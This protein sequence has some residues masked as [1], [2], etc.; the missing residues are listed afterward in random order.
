[1]STDERTGI[2]ML[3][4]LESG[5]V[6][7]FLILVL[8]VFL[9]IGWAFP[10]KKLEFCDVTSHVFSKD[11]NN[12][13]AV[14]CADINQDGLIDIYFNNHHVEP[15][16]F[17]IN[18]GSGTFSDAWENVG[19]R[20]TPWVSE[21][22]TRPLFT[23]EQFGYFIW[24]DEVYQWRWKI[25]WCSGGEKHHF[26]GKICPALPY[27]RE[28]VLMKEPVLIGEGVEAELDQHGCITFSGSPGAG[29]QGLDIFLKRPPNGLQFDLRIDGRYQHKSIFV[30]G[31]KDSPTETPFSLW[32]SDRHACSW[33]DYNNDGYPDLFINRGALQGDLKPPLAGKLD[34]LYR[35]KRDGTLENV[36][37]QSGFT[38]NYLS[39]R[40]AMWVDINGDSFLDLTIGS[41][42]NQLVFYCNQDGKY[43]KHVD[44]HGVEK[45]DCNFF[46]WL[47]IDSDGDQDLLLAGCYEGQDALFLNTGQWNFENIS[48]KAGFSDTL[49]IYQDY[50]ELK[51]KGIPF[52]GAM[53]F[54]ADYDN[55]G[56]FDLLFGSPDNETGCRLLRNK[57]DISFE[58]I[59]L[60]AGL[61][62]QG[63]WK[64][65]QWADY[66]NDG[67]L[68]LFLPA[69]KKN[70]TSKLFNNNSGKFF[71]VT[72]E[73]KLKIKQCAAASF[74]DYNNDGFLDL[75]AQSQPGGKG[76]ENACADERNQPFKK[77][78]RHNR[79]FRNLGNQNHWLFIELRGIKSNR[80]G[81]GAR[82]HLS[83]GGKTQMRQKGNLHKG[84]F[85]QNLL[86]M[87]FGLGS[88][89][90]V[91]KIVIYWPSGIRQVLEN[92]PADQCLKITE[93]L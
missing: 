1:M 55:D 53:I 39:G 38:P 8:G 86:P 66:D 93:P 83:A 60:E 51:Q 15:S 68:D 88:S 41:A 67:D 84:R 49:T 3:A 87:H 92:I 77:V 61:P 13:F 81:L 82:I 58:N 34:E 47:D 63:P 65:G 42:N 69:G 40:S 72:K 2:Y 46:N 7:T 64:E 85:S 22:F 43:F 28:T 11:T 78:G 57:G 48:T 37:L 23:P 32:L 6:R 31:D 24:H 91:D 21:I 70:S 29:L 74:L 35:S 17:W 25:R 5:K 36:F 56:D 26:S 12:I 75:V 45:N 16:Q 14:S 90:K 18:D 4:Y 9:H 33:G 71:D 50:N 27:A 79:L 30:G 54:P 59:T 76:S 52:L 62:V 44:L 89:K 73:T 20:E 80:N 19:I 10:E